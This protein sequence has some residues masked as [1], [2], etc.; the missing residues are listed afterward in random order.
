MSLQCINKQNGFHILHLAAFRGITSTVQLI[1]EKYR[2]SPDIKVDATFNQLTPLMIAAQEGH[3]PIVQLLHQR[4]H[5]RANMVDENGSTALHLASQRNKMDV[6]RYLVQCMGADMEMVR[7]Q[8]GFTCLIVAT[9][10]GHFDTVRMLLD[11]GA[12]IEAISFDG[13]TTAQ[14][15]LDRYHFSLLR[16]LIS[17]GS[18]IDYVSD[19]R[20]SVREQTR[21]GSLQ[22]REC[23]KKGLIEYKTHHQRIKMR[24]SEH[25]VFCGDIIEIIMN[26]AY[27]IPMLLD[28]QCTKRKLCMKRPYR[29]L[30]ENC[31]PIKKQ[32][33]TF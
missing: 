1:M 8:D 21:S 10:C 7:K 11:L 25:T 31:L 9:Y 17:K 18:D 5:A 26:L 2:I 3:L 29:N 33:K 23:V 20:Q 14:I 12:N 22:L 16:L 4:Y 28:Q 13:S 30:R 15:S 32:K 24:V 6:V 27:P 19:I